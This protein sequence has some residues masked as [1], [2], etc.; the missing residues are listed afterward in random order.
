MLMLLLLLLQCALYLPR[1]AVLREP[2]AGGLHGG[3][4]WLGGLPVG[5]ITLAAWLELVCL[6]FYKCM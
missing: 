6:L 4:D 3:S 2:E 1:E 5:F